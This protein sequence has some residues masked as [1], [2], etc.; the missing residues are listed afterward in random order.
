M[1]YI[2]LPI[3]AIVS[4][5]SACKPNEPEP[6]ATNN[7]APN[8]VNIT[9]KVLPLFGGQTLSWPF[10]YTTVA[11]DTIQFD[12][13]KF[14]LS[15]FTLE[16]TDGALVT[17]PETY[18]YLS[19]KDGRD[20]VVLR[21]V[22]KGNYKSFRFQVGLDSAVNH[23]DPASRSLDHPLSPALNEMH[24]GWAG[25]YIFNVVEGYY[26]SKGQNAG[27][28]FHVAL[29][30]NNRVHTFVQNFSIASDARMLLNLHADKYFS[31][32]INYSLKTDGAFSHSGDVDPVMDKFMQNMNGIFEFKSIK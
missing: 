29:L 15:N 3:L 7:P 28:S 13:V 8:G 11:G 2:I 25:G 9:M 21:N 26:R 22:P 12:K 30:K 23:S 31:N 16:T 32:T 14:L 10:A 6:P 19:M 17:L 18:A 5:F 4:F 1:K 20:S 24:W 27:F